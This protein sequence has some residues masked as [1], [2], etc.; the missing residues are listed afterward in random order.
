MNSKLIELLVNLRDIYDMFG[1]VYGEKAYSRAIAEI[2]KLDFQINQNTIDKLIKLKLPSIGKSILSKIIE[3]A[4]DGQID[5]LC[6]LQ[7]SKKLA[8]YREL[9]KILGVGPT[10][11]DKWIRLG[12]NSLSDLRAEVGAGNIVL[13]NMQKWGLRYYIDLNK[14][15]PRDEVTAI[16][17]YMKEKILQA[18]RD[19][20]F[21]VAGSYRRNSRDSGDI[22]IIITNK[23]K[24][25]K[26]LLSS[27]AENLHS[28][29]QFIAIISL[30][31]ER[32]TFLYKSP[33]SNCVRQIDI[34]NISYNSYYAA[35]LYFTGD[36]EFNENIR[37]YAKRRGFK[38]NQT[39]L[40][41]LTGPQ[42]ARKE[43]LIPTNSEQEIFEI[44]GLSYIEP[45]NR[46]GNVVI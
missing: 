19:I 23:N 2:K 38:L 6:K 24:F 12:V 3:Y 15:I 27:I 14:R 20:I 25:N 32:L 36:A 18:D 21:E 17:S 16:C 44:L 46:I 5:E 7:T 13:N 28:D 11:I 39:G 34:L 43:K 10:T 35:L 40:F 42:D 8:T 30:G 31:R 29:R 4:R 22:D 33:L 1:N 45:Q 41:K 37:G 9:T 26:D